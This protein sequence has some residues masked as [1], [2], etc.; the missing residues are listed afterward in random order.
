MLFY[1][2]RT[3]PVA[4]CCG[5]LKNFPD[6]I[7]GVTW[8]SMSSEPNKAK[9]TQN[10]CDNVVGGRTKA[11]CAGSCQM[12]CLKNLYVYMQRNLSLITLLLLIILLYI[13]IIYNYSICLC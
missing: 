8:G 12:L 1:L 4:L 2:F 11:K 10:N 5:M 3:E 13:L 9:W 7:P 6:M